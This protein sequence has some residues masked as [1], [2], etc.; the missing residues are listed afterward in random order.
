MTLLQT[1][2]HFLLMAFLAMVFTGEKNNIVANGNKETGRAAPA[3]T[4]AA[5]APFIYRDGG[6]A[7]VKQ[8][9]LLPAELVIDTKWMTTCEPVSRLDLYVHGI[10]APQSF[11]FHDNKFW[12]LEEKNRRLV[13]LD[14]TTNTLKE[15]KLRY[16][17]YG[18][19]SKIDFF[20][21]GRGVS[22]GND[23]IFLFD[24][25]HLDQIFNEFQLTRGWDV[26]KNDMIA[27]DY[28]KKY[29]FIIYDS[30][31]KVK[32]TIRGDMPIDL[33]VKFFRK[34]VSLAATGTII[35]AAHI[36]YG[37]LEIFDYGGKLLRA[38]RI[39]YTE[40]KE[41]HN[42]KKMGTSGGPLYATIGNLNAIDDTCYFMLN[43]P[44]HH[45]VVLFYRPSSDSWSC[46][47]LNA[48]PNAMI[49]Q[50]QVIAKDPELE[51]LA[52]QFEGGERYAITTFS[53]DVNKLTP[54]EREQP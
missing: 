20:E 24:A 42:V 54:V 4:L 45:P 9:G 30:N 3:A 14:A 27:I 21:D 43:N 52:L 26:F 50:V 13:I 8:D 12:I 39:P 37:G 23:D 53:L 11:A 40:L 19:V 17:G 48:G 29:S 51:I 16:R 1:F 6:G 32:G 22:I 36:M 5:T 15:N 25:D 33:K 34:S 46:V 28:N 44:Y 41:K 18:S 31:M 47:A 7:T 10:T 35:Y 49:D 38:V 2:F